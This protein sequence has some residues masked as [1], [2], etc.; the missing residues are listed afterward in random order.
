LHYYRDGEFLSLPLEHLQGTSYFGGEIPSGELGNRTYYYFEAMDNL[1]NKVLLPSSAS[2]EFVSEYNYFEVRFEGKPT[3]LLLL[4]HIVLMLASLIIL[5]HAL[6]YAIF[7]LQ[8]GES[9]EKALR[10]SIVGIVTFFITGFPIGWIIE[11]QVLGNYWEG[12]PFGWDITDNKTLLIFLIW[13]IIIMLKKTDKISLRAFARWVIINT[14]ITF[15][16]FLVPHSI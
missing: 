10:S 13:L 6:Y 14:I 8:T 12:I 3:F 16:L 7:F 15:A 2:K 5:I 9:G 1:A 4:L 11:K